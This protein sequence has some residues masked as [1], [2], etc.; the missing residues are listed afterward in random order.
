MAN[1]IDCDAPDLLTDDKSVHVILTIDKI[2]MDDLFEI[3]HF[4]IEKVFFDKRVLMAISQF[5]RS[6]CYLD[7]HEKK[8]NKIKKMRKINDEIYLVE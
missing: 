6:S 1:K 5:D 3:F 7:L 4:H 8:S 2:E